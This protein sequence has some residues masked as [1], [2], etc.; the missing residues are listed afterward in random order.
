MGNAKSV[1]EPDSSLDE[2]EFNVL[3]IHASSAGTAALTTAIILLAIVGI[4]IQIKRCRRRGCCLSSEQPPPL[5]DAQPPA[6]PPA[7][8]APPPVPPPNPHIYN[9]PTPSF[10]IGLPISSG[11]YCLAAP[12]FDR[13]RELN[14]MNEDDD[15]SEEFPL[16]TFQR[17]R[18]RGSGRGHG[19]VI[20]IGRPQPTGPNRRGGR[21]LSHRDLCG[22]DRPVQLVRPRPHS[23]PNPNTNLNR[24]SSR[25]SMR[26]SLMHRL[27]ERRRLERLERE[28]ND[29]NNAASNDNENSDPP[30]Y[31]DS[32][33]DE[34]TPTPYEFEPSLT[35]HIPSN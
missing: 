13:I 18:G 31:D 15:G 30:T 32:V 28:N 24:R 34:T 27:A 29:N 22:P 20:H 26:G 11:Q 12:D 3:N 33:F 6:Q 8:P 10:P 9:F 7:Q 1:A 14:E 25:G 23:D 2:S 4:A 5:E 21:G 17:S 35:A 19:R 16:A